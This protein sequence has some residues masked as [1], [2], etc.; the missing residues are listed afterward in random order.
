MGGQL[1]SAGPGGEAASA[2]ARTWLGDRLPAL[3]VAFVLVV[4]AVVIVGHATDASKDRG[5]SRLNGSNRGE[6]IFG[7]QQ[8]DV[9]RGKGGKDKLVARNG[10]DRV[11]GGGG[12]DKMRGG[13]GDDRLIAGKG[14][15]EMFGGRGRDEFNMA[16]GVQIGGQGRDVIHA[17]DGEADEI[18][19]GP[20]SNDVA[21]V[22]GSEDGVYDCERVVEPKEGV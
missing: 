7:T 15:A 5:S 4:A 8:G 13:K 19:C 10:P 12:H 6:T 20:G 21:Y 9:I 18:N 11:F 1:N 3:L 17:R 2:R 16:D 14:G 22:D